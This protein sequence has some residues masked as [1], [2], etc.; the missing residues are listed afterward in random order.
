MINM[1]GF[2]WS[3]NVD[4]RMFGMSSQRDSYE[5][6]NVEENVY[7]QCGKSYHTNCV[8]RNL[9]EVGVSLKVSIYQCLP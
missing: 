7:R 4:S 6:Q 8:S 9:E 2:I 5:L 3:F 1:G